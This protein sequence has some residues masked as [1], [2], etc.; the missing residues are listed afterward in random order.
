MEILLLWIGRISGI[1]GVGLCGW[2]A[3]GRLTGAYFVGG[4]QVGTILLAG[5]AAILV[6][7]FF[8]LLVLTDESRR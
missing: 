4:F 5:M 2:A 8:L 3:Y 1:A 6:A 7:C